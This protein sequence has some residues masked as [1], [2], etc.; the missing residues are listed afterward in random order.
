MVYSKSRQ[1]V[2]SCQ[3]PLFGPDRNVLFGALHDCTRLYGCRQGWVAAGRA[4]GEP[5]PRPVILTAPPNVPRRA[6]G[7]EARRFRREPAEYEAR[8]ISSYC[9]FP[10]TIGAQRRDRDLEEGSHFQEIAPMN[11][12]TTKSAAS[13]STHLG[14]PWLVVSLAG[15]AKS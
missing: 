7:R 15:S 8:G 6:A 3:A 10:W 13:T 4:V 2:W 1:K 9:H 5:A 11:I 14:V 12:A